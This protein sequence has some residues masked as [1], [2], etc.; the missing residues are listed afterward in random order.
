M[1]DSNRV[2]WDQVGLFAGVVLAIPWLLT[3][4]MHLGLLEYAG[5]TAG[6]VAVLAMWAPT[7]ATAVLL[8]TLDRG[9]DV[10]WTRRVGLSV[11]RGTLWPWLGVLGA[12][13]LLPILLNLLGP[14][15][16]AG[17]GTMELDLVEFSGLRALIVAQ[18]G[19][20]ALEAL[21]VPLW[22]IVAVTPLQ[23]VLGAVINVVLG[24]MGEELGWRG[25]LL[26][27]LL[28]LGRWPAMLAVGALW[29]IWHAP[30]ILL[31]HNYPDAPVLGVLLFVP[32]CMIWGVIHGWAR[33]ASDSVWPP[34]LMHGALNASAGF[35]LMLLASGSTPSSL[36][37]APVGLA[38]L[39]LPVVVVLGLAVA[40]RR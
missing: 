36:L 22:V 2:P 18:G 4:P 34:A 28:P 12:A 33:L 27:K 5:I 38:S 3:A 8:L 23:A 30:L 11:P 20:A 29:G 17:L 31:G 32:F 15:V 39:V 21:P 19:E 9:G 16:A 14:F 35:A 7:V 25:W 6:A 40:W 10:H 1:E 24:A 26:P 37:A 13:W